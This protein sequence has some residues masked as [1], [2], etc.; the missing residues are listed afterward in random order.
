LARAELD[1]P[2]QHASTRQPWWGSP[3]LW[4]GVGAAAVGAAAVILFVGDG[5][6]SLEIGI[7]A[8]EFG[9]C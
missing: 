8:C 3:W 4:G 5:D 7:P 1:A 9:G 2:P 6:R